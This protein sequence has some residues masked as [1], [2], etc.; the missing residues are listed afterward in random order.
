MCCLSDW[1]GGFAP[2]AR[3]AHGVIRFKYRLPAAT[4]T[5]GCAPPI[6]EGPGVDRSTGR[7]TRR[8]AFNQ[9]PPDAAAGGGRSSLVRKV[10]LIVN[11]FHLFTLIDQTHYL[12]FPVYYRQVETQEASINRAGVTLGTPPR[13]PSQLG[14]AA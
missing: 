8:C 14:G 9:K 7:A 6:G 11:K 4:Q 2:R 3:L 1:F 12:C 5:P 13:H 10:L